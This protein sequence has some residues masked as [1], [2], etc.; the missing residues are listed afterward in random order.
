[1]RSICFFNSTPS[2]GGGEAWHLGAARA[3]A[4]RGYRVVV[5]GSPGSELV[6]RARAVGMETAA[7]PVTNRSW[8]NPLLLRRLR[9][10]FEGRRV[11]TVVFNGPA[12]LKSGGLA[13]RAAG[14]PRRVYRRGL[15]VPVRDHPVNRYLF[16][17]VLTHVVANS[18]ETRRN[19]F[20]EMGAVV[21]AERVA[22][23]PNGIDLEVFDARAARSSQERGEG[24]KERLRLGNVGR[25]AAQK[26]QRLLLD[27]ARIL[28]DRGL[29]V[30]LLVAGKGELE[31]ELR[32]ETRRRDLEG[33][34]TFTGFEH[35]VPGFLGTLDVFL[36]SSLWEGFGNVILEAGAARLPTVALDLSSN[37][38]TVLDGTTGF[39]VPPDDVQAFADRVALLAEDE[40]LR[41][42]MGAAA[43][44][45]VEERFRFSR[46][47][48]DLE[49]FLD[50]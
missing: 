43:R 45:R 2:W 22:V 20:R 42:R 1:V 13:A 8:L 49:R 25:L 16:T 29:D 38:E 32:A 44:A 33:S 37:P 36:L 28:A 4:A 6:E 31:E 9:R 10:F 15:A 50:V 18:E 27:V 34:V 5:V 12:D 46:T 7:F 40:D 48:D 11:G 26:N 14:V 39:L 3:F 19:L 17:R 21:P 35:D 47:M 41:A 24:R 30:H 23:I